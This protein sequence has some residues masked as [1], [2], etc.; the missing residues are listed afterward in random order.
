MVDATADILVE[1]VDEGTDLVQS[2]VTRTLAANFENLILT[3]SSGLFGTGN[4]V[5]N[6]ITG[7]TGANTLSGLDGNDTLIGGGGND[8]LTGGIGADHFVFNSTSSGIDVI[9]DFNE[10]NGGGEEGDA[11]RFDGL[12]LGTFAY[13]GTGGFSGGADNSEARVSGNQVLFDANGDGTADI[14][15]TLTGLTNASQLRE[16]YFI[17]V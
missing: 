10:L 17:F 7:N 8:N 5:A 11:L 2:S 12:L 13:L 3:G 4:S 16:S 1:N 6:V 15:L 9:S 14:T